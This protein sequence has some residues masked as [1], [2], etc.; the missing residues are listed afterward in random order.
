MKVG[1]G[2]NE[3]DLLLIL[4][5]LK[6]GYKY[7]SEEALILHAAGNI[8]NKNGIFPCLTILRTGMYLLPES[9]KIKSDYIL[10]LWE[11][12]YE[13][14]DNESIYEEILEL[15]PKIDM[16]DIYSEAKESIYKIQSKIDN[17]NS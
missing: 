2:Y 13:N 3:G 16:K 6:L 15:I 9:S 5:K 12:S 8:R 17:E 11:K 4:N 1:S 7:D 10:G 14:K